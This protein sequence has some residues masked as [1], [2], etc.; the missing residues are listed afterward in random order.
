[1]LSR[2]KILRPF[3][4][5]DHM[6]VSQQQPK[7]H[8]VTTTVRTL[9][10]LEVFLGEVFPFRP[11]QQKMTAALYYCYYVL[12]IWSKNASVVRV[13]VMLSNKFG[14]SGQGSVDMP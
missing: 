6:I 9:V 3:G 1:M 13:D 8:F 2:Q 12:L 7:I 4:E 5:N 14:S 11:Y 10:L